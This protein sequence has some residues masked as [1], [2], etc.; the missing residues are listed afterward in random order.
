LPPIGAETTAEIARSAAQQIF[1]N[2]QGVKCGSRRDLQK[3]FDRDP[4]QVRLSRRMGAANRTEFDWSALR[5]GQFLTETA[6]GLG[7][8]SDVKKF[9]PGKS[10]PKPPI[11]PDG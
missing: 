11:C 10:S 1:P 5:A 2:Y 9:A 6:Y 7:A 4:T 8:H 3:K